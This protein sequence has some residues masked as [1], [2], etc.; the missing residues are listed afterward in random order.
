MSYPAGQGATPL[1]F[2]ELK[3]LRV[4]FTQYVMYTLTHFCAR[5]KQGLTPTVEVPFDIDMT[6]FW[7]FFICTN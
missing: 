2:V 6:D 5:K 1:T 7:N 4:N 3:T